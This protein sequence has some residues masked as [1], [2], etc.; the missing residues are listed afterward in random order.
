[1]M[2][3]APNAASP[4]KKT[5]GR[6]DAMV[7]AST[8]GIPQR[9]NSMP[10]SRSIHGKAFSCP[11]ATRMSSHSKL[12]SGSPVGI[13]LRRPFSSYLADTFSNT[14]PVSRPLSCST[15]LGTR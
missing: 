6:V 8:T 11:T 9:S 12:T 14:M 2:F 13:R 15:S 1:M 4:P 5:P 10:R 7:A 3:S